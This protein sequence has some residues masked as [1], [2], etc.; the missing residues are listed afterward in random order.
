MIAPFLTHIHLGMVTLIV[1]FALSALSTFSCAWLCTEHNPTESRARAAYL[2]QKKTGLYRRPPYPA[3]APKDALVLCDYCI[4]YVQRGAKHC[5]S[6]NRCVA[7]F[8]HHCNFVNNCIDGQIYRTFI[9][10]LV[11][12]LS[13]TGLVIALNVL[14]IADA[15]SP[16]PS[17]LPEIE[18]A[19]GFNDVV[20]AVIC[21]VTALLALV[22]FGMIGQLFSF[23]VLLIY[24]GMTTYDY[25]IHQRDK[26]ESE[27]NA[28][29]TA[30]Q[31]ARQS[32]TISPPQAQVAEAQL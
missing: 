24:K 16:D 1:A 22:L 10:L 30:E 8:D 29:K 3:D 15:F 5:H 17:L 11:S 28:A 18:D 6:C 25:I 32:T 2:N 12:V 20:V 26:K 21:G 14:M 13:L 23:H 27:R 19:Y 4:A 9:G 31:M 7:D